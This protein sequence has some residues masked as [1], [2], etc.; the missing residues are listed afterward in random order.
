MDKIDSF[1][2]QFKNEME[3]GLREKDIQINALQA[4]N[5]ELK[6][7]LET[8]EKIIDA[9]ARQIRKIQDDMKNT[10]AR[11]RGLQMLKDIK[12]PE[13]EKKK[14]DVKELENKVIE[15]ENARLRCEYESLKS[16]VGNLQGVLQRLMITEPD[17][18][19]D[20]NST[21]VR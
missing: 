5:R 2:T 16:F 19:R 20:A 11:A 7:R 14:R 8:K 10:F 13:G 4:S 15:D 9:Q 17:R 18:T 12:D 21:R 6:D 3:R 1:Y